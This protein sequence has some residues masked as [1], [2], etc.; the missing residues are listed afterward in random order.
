[1]RIAWASLGKF[2]DNWRYIGDDIVRFTYCIVAAESNVLREE[3]MK[4]K[5]YFSIDGE[6]QCHLVA[7]TYPAYG[8][9]ILILS[10]KLLPC[11]TR[12]RFYKGQVT[13][14]FDA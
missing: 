14:S 1:L 5:S 6:S 8:N 2:E 3:E 7:V 13:K 10:R 11:R 12:F 4:Y 9:P